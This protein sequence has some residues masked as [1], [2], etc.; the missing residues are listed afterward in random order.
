MTRPRWP[1]RELPTKRASPAIEGQLR[2]TPGG[3]FVTTDGPER[4]VSS[5]AEMN[6]AFDGFLRGYRRRFGL[7]RD[8][9]T[10]ALVHGGTGSMEVTLVADASLPLGRLHELAGVPGYADWERVLVLAVETPTGEGAVPFVLT[11]TRAE[12]QVELP[13]TATFQSLADALAN[14]P[15]DH[16]PVVFITPL[17]LDNTRR[18]PHAS[19]S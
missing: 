13:A 10:G 12:A 14:R 5:A 16:P 19:E 3:A 15:P 2:L 11:T 1:R 9:A 4:A 17:P 7:R 8:R 6:E 18:N